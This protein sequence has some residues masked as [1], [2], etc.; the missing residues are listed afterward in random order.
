MKRLWLRPAGRYFYHAVTGKVPRKVVRAECEKRIV[1]KD[2]D[3]H[4]YRDDGDGADNRSQCRWCLKAL[5]KK[6]KER[7]TA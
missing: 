6:T 2:G 4:I 1:P 3:M 5:R 7:E